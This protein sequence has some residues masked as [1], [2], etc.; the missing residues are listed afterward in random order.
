MPSQLYPEITAILNAARTGDFL[1]VRSCTAFGW[2]IRRMLS[3][4]L[5]KCYGNH[6]APV[7][8]EDGDVQVMNLQIETPAAHIMPLRDYLV[9][10]YNDGGKAILLRPDA[11]ADFTGQE[12]FM[13][14]AQ[15]ELAK[16]WKAENGLKYDKYS[17]RV[18][19]RIIFRYSSNIPE[20]KKVQVYCTEGTLY[21]FMDNPYIP[22][23]PDELKN[24]Q[25]PAPIH[26]ENMIRQGRI[27][28]VA[29]NDELYKNIARDGG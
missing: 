11:Y 2:L 9:A 14:A 12:T 29:G 23:R 18:F 25:Y 19:F 5:H 27:D 16:R 1:H 26:V 17:I 28:F 8:K 22:W 13:R 3:L 20:N 10:L 15:A 7:W 4:G 6:N 21:P 24:E